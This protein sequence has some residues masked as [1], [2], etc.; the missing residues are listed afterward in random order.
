LWEYGWIERYIGSAEGCN[1]RLDEMQ[2]AILRVK[3]INL[4]VDNTIREKHAI[5]Y[6]NALKGLSLELPEIR[7]NSTHVYRLYGVKT[8]KRDDL[9]TFLKEHGINTTIQYPVPIHR[10]K[11]YE[12]IVDEVSL[13]VTEQAT[14]SILS[15]TMYPELTS[16]EINQTANVIKD[17]YDE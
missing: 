4:N 1:S 2:A 15:L 14:E 16:E 17:Y 10:Q 11:C 8:E 9:Q 6:Q 12:K 7:N 13:P 5:E 3:I